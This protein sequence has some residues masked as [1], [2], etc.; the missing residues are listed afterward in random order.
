MSLFVN[1][2]F[3][4]HLQLEFYN[5][6]FFQQIEQFNIDVNKLYSSLNLC[7]ISLEL[8]QLS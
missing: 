1:V 4:N 5:D 8:I 6:Y 7:I 3:L 2:D